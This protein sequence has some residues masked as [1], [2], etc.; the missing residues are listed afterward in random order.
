MSYNI[1][2][3]MVQRLREKNGQVYCA[4]C[5]AKDLEQDPSEVILAPRQNFSPGSCPCG[6]TGIMLRW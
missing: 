1:V 6:Q 2:A 4:D 3:S 5:L